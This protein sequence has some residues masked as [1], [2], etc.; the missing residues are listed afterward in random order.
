MYVYIYIHTYVYV[1]I[2]IYIYIYTHT[3]IHTYTISAG[4]GLCEVRREPLRATTLSFSS[5][6][7]C[8]FLSFQQK[9]ICNLYVYFFI[10]TLLLFIVLAETSILFLCFF[11]HGYAAPFY[12]FS[13]DIYL[14]SMFIS[15]WLRYS[16][17]L[18]QQRRLSYHYVYFFMVTLLLLIQYIYICYIYIYTRIYIISYTYIYIHIHIHYYFTAGGGLCEVPCASAALQQ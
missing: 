16:F 1:C 9:H 17:L 7:H 5:V 10:L 11:L 15:S 4:G 13:R 3:Y 18:F 12:Y 8:S 14:I 6:L 2:Y